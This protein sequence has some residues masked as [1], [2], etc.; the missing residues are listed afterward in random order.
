ML[1]DRRANKLGNHLTAEQLR[2]KK[3]SSEDPL[4]P[5]ALMINHGGGTRVLIRS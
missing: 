5:V 1:E 3:D 4:D 2:K